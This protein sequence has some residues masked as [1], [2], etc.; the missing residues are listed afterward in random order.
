[1][2]G[3]LS[4]IVVPSEQP[5]ADDKEAPMAYQHMRALFDY[6]PEVSVLEIRALKCTGN[7]E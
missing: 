4:L 6:D 7:A 1:M 3:E 5:S 2:S